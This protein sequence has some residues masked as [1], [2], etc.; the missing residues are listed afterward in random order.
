[1]KIYTYSET[2][3]LISRQLMRLFRKYI[4]ELFA[5]GVFFSRKMPREKLK[6]EKGGAVK[7]A[8]TVGFGAKRMYRKY[9]Y[10]QRK[11]QISRLLI[12]NARE[13]GKNN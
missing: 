3:L 8:R 10:A 7:L 12:D 6:R 9:C 1:M 4:C 13:Y 11:K 5:R 2:N